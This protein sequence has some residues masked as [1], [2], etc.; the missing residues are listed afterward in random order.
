MKKDLLMIISVIFALSWVDP[1]GLTDKTRCPETSIMWFLHAAKKRR[2]SCENE[3]T[4]KLCYQVVRYG[5]HGIW[6]KEDG[7]SGPED[8]RA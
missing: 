2:Q 6:N 3:Y 4:D 5:Q 7:G 8:H 1:A